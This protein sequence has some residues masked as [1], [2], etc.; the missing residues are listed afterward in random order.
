MLWTAR[1]LEPDADGNFQPQPVGLV[2]FAIDIVRTPES[3]GVPTA[4]VSAIP[5][6]RR[7]RRLE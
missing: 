6:T 2:K 3:E 4:V 5:A 1:V 7:H